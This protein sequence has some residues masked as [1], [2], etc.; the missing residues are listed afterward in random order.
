MASF[1]DTL[2]EAIELTKEKGFEQSRAEW[3]MLLI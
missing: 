2:Q 1:K 3:L